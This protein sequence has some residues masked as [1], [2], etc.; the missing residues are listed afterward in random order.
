[1][2]YIGR[3]LIIFI[4]FFSIGYISICF[5]SNKMFNPL[6]VLGSYHTERILDRVEYSHEV[7][8]TSYYQNEPKKEEFV[9]VITIPQFPSIRTLKFTMLT[10]MVE[11]LYYC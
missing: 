5:I 9:Y 3:F 6:D 11:R 4:G 2:K 1:M 10:N 8:D 7:F